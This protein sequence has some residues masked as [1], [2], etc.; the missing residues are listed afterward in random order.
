MSAD[1]STPADEIDVEEVRTQ[2]V[3]ALEVAAGAVAG[4]CH[5]HADAVLAG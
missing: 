3:A 1:M 5:G 2:L 4:G